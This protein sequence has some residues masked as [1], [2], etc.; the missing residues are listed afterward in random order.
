MALT[1][2]TTTAAETASRQAGERASKRE[3]ERLNEQADGQADGHTVERRPVEAGKLA[4]GNQG[5]S[6]VSVLESL[7]LPL[8]SAASL[9]GLVASCTLLTLQAVLYNNLCMQ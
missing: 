5:Q 3:S 8:D 9:A 7:Q 1:T 4:P 2:S 6:L